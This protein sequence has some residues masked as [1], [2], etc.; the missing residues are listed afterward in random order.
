MG[1]IQAGKEQGATVHVGGVQGPSGFYVTP[2]LFT[3]VSSDMTIM[4][5]EI[6]GP[7]GAV[8]KFD[9]EAGMVSPFLLSHLTIFI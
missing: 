5:E 3:D 6:F 9:D 4:R 1:Y 2:T 8:I 7:V